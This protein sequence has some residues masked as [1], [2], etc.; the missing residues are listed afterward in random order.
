MESR[1]APVTLDQR[2]AFASQ[3]RASARRDLLLSSLLWLIFLAFGVA[4]HL[5]LALLLPAAAISL[6]PVTTYR[7][8]IRNAQLAE[9]SAAA[10]RVLEKD[11]ERIVRARR[12]R[13]LTA[14]PTFLAFSWSWV[15]LSDAGLSH[16]GWVALTSGSIFLI[17][18]S[19]HW[20]VA[21]PQERLPKI[22][23][24]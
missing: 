21:P 13:V 22:A 3:L 6:V 11:Y 4:M 23:A 2:R 14:S 5:P 8:R 10:A 9:S 1:S 19:I 7:L 18:W 24:L 17:A 16:A 15:L 12:R 20:Y